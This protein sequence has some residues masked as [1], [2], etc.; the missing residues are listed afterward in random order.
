MLTGLLTVFWLAGC[1]ACPVA[2]CYNGRMVY[3]L[4]SYL[5][6]WL[7]YCYTDL[8]LQ[9]L[10]DSYLISWLAE[11]V[12]DKMAVRLADKSDV[13]IAVWI[14][15]WL[16]KW[17]NWWVKWPTCIALWLSKGEVTQLLQWLAICESKL[18]ELLTLLANRKL[19]SSSLYMEPRPCH[20]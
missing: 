16:A 5:F 2:I 14:V 3:L 19:E 8:E 6:C 7:A 9:C 15:A 12:P 4:I 18:T 10:A 1:Y 20:M 13:T 17:V 11:C